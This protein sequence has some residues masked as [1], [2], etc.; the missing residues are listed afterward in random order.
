MEEPVQFSYNDTRLYGILHIP[1]QNDF[2]H[3]I[4]TMVI[5]GPQTR[6][7]SHR[8]Y[9]QLARFLSAHGISV[10]RFD[11]EGM[12][13]SD[14]N[15]VGFE[16][17]RPSIDAAF[18]FLFQRF[19]NSFN[20]IIWSLC[21]GSS[22]CLLYAADNNSKIG[23]MVL[24]NPIIH[25]DESKYRKQYYKIRL[26][27]KEFWHRLF[28]LRINIF[29]ILF[30]LFDL[31]KNSVSLFFKKPLVQSESYHKQH[32]SERILES[33]IKCDMPIKFILSANDFV[34]KE[35][36]IALHSKKIIRR[37]LQKKNV[38]E[39]LIKEADHTFTQI[40]PRKK[41]FETTLRAVHEIM[42]HED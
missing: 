6:V 10:F 26:S 41:F 22:A 23:G 15:F 19:P 31:L 4:V 35:F 9:V 33:I 30:D 39:F 21:D 8:L 12:G 1:D 3:T 27:Q 17:T 2:C 37:L 38:F 20:N 36:Q 32:I 18:D 5:G 7:G 14:G 34:A 40:E 28:T 16:H 13:D 29:E 42:R 11:Y 24:C 25:F